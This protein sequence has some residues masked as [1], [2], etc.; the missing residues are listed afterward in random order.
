LIALAQG[1]TQFA[2][3]GSYKILV[4]VAAT[5]CTMM[6]SF[7]G[8]DRGEVMPSKRAEYLEKADE[9]R[10]RAANSRDENIREQ[11]LS[12]AQEWEEMAEEVRRRKSKPEN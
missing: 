7:L 10:R 1:P 4:P 12:L 5:G 9:C 11:F 8:L 2:A 6:R 3:N